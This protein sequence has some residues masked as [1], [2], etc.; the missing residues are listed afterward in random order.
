MKDQQSDKKWSGKK[1]NVKNNR[2]MSKNK[3]RKKCL[4]FQT[5]LRHK[6]KKSHLATITGAYKPRPPFGFLW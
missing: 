6:E 3:E 1:K 2:T 5:L 4:S